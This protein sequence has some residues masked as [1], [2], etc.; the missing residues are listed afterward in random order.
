MISLSWQTIRTR[1]SG[2]VGAF[3]AV[4]CGT[5]LVCA[6]GVLIESGI[7]AGVAPERYSAADVVVGANDSVRPDTMSMTSVSEQPTVDAGLVD[8][9]AGIPGVRAAIGDVD[10]PAAVLS[11][12]KPSR[13]HGWDATALGAFTLKLGTEPHGPDQVV[14][15]ANLDKTTTLGQRVRI[16]TPSGTE[17]YQV[18]GLVSGS[19][20]RQSAVFFSPERARELFG[21][22]GRV[23]AVGVLANPGVSAGDLAERIENALPDMTVATGSDRSAVEFSDVGAARTTL[24]ALASSFGG[25]VLMVMV[26]V[27]S[28]TLAL[29]VTQRRREFALLRAIAA[30]PKQIRKLIGT[31]TLLVAGVAGLLGSLGGLL[32]A[33]VLRDAF[34]GIGLLPTD[35]QLA[36]GPLPVVGAWLLG[37]GAARLAAWTAG[38]RP[39]RISPVEA[40][41]EAAVERRD[42]GRARTVVGLVAVAIGV[43][44]STLPLYVKGSFVSGLSVLATLVIVIGVGLLGPKVVGA[45]VRLLARPLRR[46]GVGGYLAAANSTANT[47]RLAAAITPL[48]LAVGFAVAQFFSQTTTTD[49]VQRQTQASTVADHVLVSRLGALPPRVAAETRRL[50]GVAAATSVVHTQ[51]FTESSTGDDN[52]EITPHAALGVDGDQVHATIDLGSVTGDLADLTGD[53]VALSETEAG[54]L[55]KHLGDPVDFYFGDGVAAKLRLV[56]T[57]THDLAFGDFVLPAELARAH[58]TDTVDSS[59]LVRMDPTADDAVLRDLTQAFPSL[60]IRDRTAM[61]A[62]DTADQDQRFWVNLIAFGIVL[63]YIVISVANTLVMTTAQRAREFALLRLIGTT[64]GQVRRMARTE[65]LLIGGIAV[66]VGSLIPLLPLAFLGIGLAGD[67]VPAGPL[68]VYLGILAA[69]ILLGLLAIT[70]PTRLSLRNRPID[71]IG[72]RD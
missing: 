16:E 32:V 52:V 34:A 40:L 22:P 39:S 45:A 59:V 70:V 42:L 12:N 43:G 67:P 35:F 55:D 7:R 5:A 6:C 56:A 50:P 10:F 4:L 44:G 23:H 11:A 61:T 57:Y 15:D 64:R 38:R 33:G 47:R 36:M 1:L 65:A 25:V 48:M 58:T 41:G 27:V 62:A 26:F 60:D 54:W 14:L 53:T 37:V 9:V 49:A 68:A 13:G 63:G 30:T 69:A 17:E 72:L 29:S 31:E 2:F 66:V 71:A 3:L 24:V 21:R 20:A 8:R 46:T 18:V 28:G 19:L 51:V